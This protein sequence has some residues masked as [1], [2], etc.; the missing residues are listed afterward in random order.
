MENGR[1]DVQLAALPAVGR[2]K[3]NKSLMVVVF[4][5][6]LG[7]KNPKMEC[8]GS[9][10]SRTLSASTPL[11]DLDNCWVLMTKSVELFMLPS[12][13]LSNSVR[14]GFRVHRVIFLVA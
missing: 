5:A 14:S 4:L 1:V 12:N 6:P 10:R 2:V 3:P 7:P 9:F 11:Y 8:L 13:F